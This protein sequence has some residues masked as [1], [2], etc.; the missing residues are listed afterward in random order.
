MGDKIEAA[1]ATDHEHAYVTKRRPVAVPV[2]GHGTYLKTSRPLKAGAPIY[3]L[4]RYIRTKTGELATVTYAF[5]Q[6]RHAEEWGGI[7]AH[8]DALARRVYEE[9][10]R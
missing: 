9:D 5:R 1:H 7:I 2:L 10:H 4:T 6:R 3:R 8:F